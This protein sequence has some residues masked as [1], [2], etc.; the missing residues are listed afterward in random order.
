MEDEKYSVSDK[1]RIAVI[2]T[3]CVAALLFW[4]ITRD[5]YYNGY[6]AAL[7]ESESEMESVL[8]EQEQALDSAY[9]RGWRDGYSEALSESPSRAL[10]DEGFV[11][12]TAYGDRFHRPDCA[13]LSQSRIEVTLEEAMQGGYIPCSYCNP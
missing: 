10:P 11:C 2:A 7:R 5:N 1:I 9:T 13:Y 12:V 6:Q 4:F 8:Y 3:F